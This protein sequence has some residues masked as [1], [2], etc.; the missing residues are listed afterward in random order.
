MNGLVTSVW[1]SEISAATFELRQTNSNW[2]KSECRAVEYF[3]WIDGLNIADVKDGANKA[4]DRMSVLKKTQFIVKNG[5]LM[6]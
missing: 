5:W 2:I 6:K 3:D 1:F 4:T